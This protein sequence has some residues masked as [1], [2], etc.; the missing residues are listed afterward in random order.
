MAR[1]QLLYAFQENVEVMMESQGVTGELIARAFGADPNC[2]LS[3][4]STTDVNDKSF[5]YS[6]DP[7]STYLGENLTV[8][9]SGDYNEVNGLWELS[10][11]VQL[12]D[13]SHSGSGTM[14]L[15]YDDVYPKGIVD[16]VIGKFDFHSWII[17]SP[18]FSP[19][20]NTLGSLRI[21]KF[22]WEG[23]EI[24]EGIIGEDLQDESG[25]WEWL[26]SAK[27]G[28]AP[29]DLASEGIVDP[30]TLAGSF[31]MRIIP[32]PMCTEMINGDISGPYGTPD[33]H[34]NFY[35]FAALAE[36]WLESSE[37]EP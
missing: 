6:V 15:G 7:C 18:F 12:D 37:P 13:E 21:A 16:V 25:D 36:N 4:N 22:T 9:G 26:S 35:D 33:C 17:Y 8:V 14:E 2:Q 28:T 29:F 24:L 19:G 32:N 34:V 30:N 3:F 20:G 23:E 1:A 10:I 5:T 11:Y 31:T 27:G